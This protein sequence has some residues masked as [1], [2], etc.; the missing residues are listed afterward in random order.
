MKKHIPN[1]IT[2]CNLLCGAVAIVCAFAGAYASAFLFILLGAC[3]D[4]GDGATARKLGVSGPMGVELDSLA[5]DIT[6]GLA[7][8]LILF[9][10]LFPAIGWWA[11]IAL[12][13]A[14][15]SAVR[16]AK[17]NIDSRQHENFIGLATPA[18]AIFWASIA[19][20][21]LF[22]H[23]HEAVVTPGEP[24]VEIALPWVLLVLSLVSCW[25]MVSEISFFSLKFKS[26]GW[27][28]NRW[29]YIFLGGCVLIIAFCVAI[30][31]QMGH[32]TYI[33]AAGAA[34]IAW[35]V[36]MNLCIK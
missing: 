36:I 19:T 21:P 17:F 15:F 18:N 5:D 31:L 25:L 4:F 3:F 14:A 13:M 11:L 1:I 8:A 23:M 2:C 9:R 34:C 6:F 28:E 30:A 24:Y 33:L 16:L 20:L 29:R 35:Y 10:F 7:P 32:P 12:L 27:S 26:L 22:P